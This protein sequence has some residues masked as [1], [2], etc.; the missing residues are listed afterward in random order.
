MAWTPPSDAVETQASSGTAV[1]TGWTPPSDAVKVGAA[2][3]TGWTPPADAV[4]ETQEPQEPFGNAMG[5]DFGSAIMAA[6]A[7]PKPVKKQ[8]VLEGVYMPEPEY[9]REELD[10]LSRRKY[11]EEQ[12]Q[13]YYPR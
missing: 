9:N 1:N 12:A 6:S 8:S 5:E 11:A 4:E 10:R 13:I 7:L 3:V 2:P